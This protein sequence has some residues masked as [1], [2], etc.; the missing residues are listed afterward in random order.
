M[1]FLWDDLHGNLLI[2]WDKLK[3][4][5]AIGFKTLADVEAWARKGDGRGSK[6][7][8]TLQDQM[9]NTRAGTEVTPE[10]KLTE[11]LPVEGKPECSP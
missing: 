9:S 10:T 3:Y 7:Y 4:S 6:A 8:E 5:E 1:H 11:D 2:G